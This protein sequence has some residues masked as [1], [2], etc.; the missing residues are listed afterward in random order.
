MRL[1]TE[2][3]DQMELAQI[4]RSLDEDLI[5]FDHLQIPTATENTLKSPLIN[6]L[7]YENISCSVSHQEYIV[8]KTSTLKKFLKKIGKISLMP[9]N[10]R[11][12]KFIL[13]RPDFLCQKYGF[14]IEVDGNVHDNNSSKISKDE[15]RDYIYSA[16]NIQLFRIENDQ[17]H[18]PRARQRFIEDIIRWISKVEASGR[19]NQNYASLR[20]QLCIARKQFLKFARNKL[21]LPCIGSFQRKNPKREDYPTLGHAPTHI[22]WGGYRINVRP[23]AQPNPQRN[24]TK[25]N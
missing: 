5:R 21:D 13:K 1:K 12:R 25:A 22:Q 17:V 4:F 19:T 20:K 2:V 6:R 10:Y 18:N 23:L 15:L 24:S 8:I 9:S 14:A 7:Q 16:I 11:E 3:T